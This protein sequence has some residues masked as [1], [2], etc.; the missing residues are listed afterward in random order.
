MF[1]NFA[2]QYPFSCMKGEYVGTKVLFIHIVKQY[3]KPPVPSSPSSVGVGAAGL[4][5]GPGGGA[6]RQTRLS[7]TCTCCVS[8]LNT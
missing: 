6:R 5:G 1:S 3:L 4:P 7:R 2:I 8:L